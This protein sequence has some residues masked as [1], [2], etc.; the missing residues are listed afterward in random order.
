MRNLTETV[1]ALVYFIMWMASMVYITWAFTTLV[2]AS[3]DA[4]YVEPDIYDQWT[5]A[6]SILSSK[7]VE[8]KLRVNDWISNTVTSEEFDRIFTL[9]SQLQPVIAPDV[10]VEMILAVISVESGYRQDLV[11]FSDDSGLMQ[12]IP[13]F[14]RERIA[15]YLYDE[16]VDIFDVI[17]NVSSGMDYLSELTEFSSGDDALTLMAYNEG[18]TKARNRRNRGITSSYAELVMYR[19]RAIKKA[20]D[21]RYGKWEGGENPLTTKPRPDAPKHQWPE[22]HP[23]KPSKDESN[24]S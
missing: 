16:N 14:H 12:V 6:D 7:R 15:Q 20:M 19:M 11:G 18:P 4:L 8:E 24:N 2:D 3:A 22:D 21:G 9:V 17:V 5:V 10:P 23:Q 1:W 13:K